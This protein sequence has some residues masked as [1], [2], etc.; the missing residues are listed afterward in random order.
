MPGRTPT[1]AYPVE[2]TST[3]TKCSALF[4]AHV[5]GTPYYLRAVVEYLRRACLV[6]AGAIQQLHAK[7]AS[8]HRVGR[9]PADWERRRV[10]GL[11]LA[12]YLLNL[13][14]CRCPAT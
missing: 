5:F 8:S 9:C 14:G 2:A 10:D 6:F 13:C 12:R 11:Q 7:T 1:C 3:A 4:T